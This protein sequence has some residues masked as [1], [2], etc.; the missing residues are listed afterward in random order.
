MDTKK[1]IVVIIVFILILSWQYYSD[2]EFLISNTINGIQ[3][4]WVFI[5][6]GTIISIYLLFKIGEIGILENE[7]FSIVVLLGTLLIPVMLVT[8]FGYQINQKFG[9]TKKRTQISVIKDKELDILPQNPWLTIEFKN[10]KENLMVSKIL[11]YELRVGDTI[12]FKVQK[13]YFGFDIVSE[14]NKYEL[15]KE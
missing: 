2:K 12:E 1:A 15:K 11:W 8:K 6:L 13:G 4:G 3:F 9:E 14:I 5:I 10:D 7:Y